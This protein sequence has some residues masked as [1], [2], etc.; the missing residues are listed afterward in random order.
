MISIVYSAWKSGCYQPIWKN[1]HTCDKS[2]SCISTITRTI[3][4]WNTC[5]HRWTLPS[6]DK[7][8]RDAPACITF[9]QPGVYLC[10]GTK[11][12]EGGIIWGVGD[13]LTAEAVKYRLARELQVLLLS[14]P[15]SIQQRLPQR[16][17]KLSKSCKW[18]NWKSFLFFD[19][20]P[21]TQISTLHRGKGDKGGYILHSTLKNIIIT[22]LFQN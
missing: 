6:F 12:W 5:T 15:G 10:Q 17:T 7:T 16:V 2:L 20:L 9:K 18:L 13:L 22:V 11:D 4:Q 14:E 3:T 8:S 1:A 19:L 21:A